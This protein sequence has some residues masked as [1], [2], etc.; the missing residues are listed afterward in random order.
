MFAT[1]KGCGGITLGVCAG[2][3]C[4]RKYDGENECEGK[5][6]GLGGEHVG[7]RLME[8]SKEESWKSD[9]KKRG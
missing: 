6:F 5:S 8:E 4:E 1:M 3:Q 7:S 2:H 9:K